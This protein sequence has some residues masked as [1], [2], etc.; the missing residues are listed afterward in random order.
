[1]SMQHT[2]KKEKVYISFEFEVTLHLNW[3]APV[4]IENS[5]PP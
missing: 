4:K 3:V 5:Q 1:M 2:Q